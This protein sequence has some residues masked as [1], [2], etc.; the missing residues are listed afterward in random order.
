M[1]VLNSCFHQNC[2]SFDTEGVCYIYC[3]ENCLYSRMNL[4]FLSYT[5]KIKYFCLHFFFKTISAYMCASERCFH[6]TEKLTASTY[7]GDLVMVSI[8]QTGVCV[9]VCVYMHVCACVRAHAC[10]CVCVCVMA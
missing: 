4:I 6:D 10:V 3:F 1:P 2:I 5:N 7:P 9:C 8:D